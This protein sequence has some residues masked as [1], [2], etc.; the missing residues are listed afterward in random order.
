M[1]RDTAT[2]RGNERLFSKG[3]DRNSKTFSSI[4]NLET[5]QFILKSTTR[6][7]ALWWRIDS[8]SNN[9]IENFVNTV[10]FKESTWKFLKVRFSFRIFFGAVLTK[11]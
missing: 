10:T 11:N 1:K 7:E 4:D 5:V 6:G 3:R 8:F 2:L 9:R